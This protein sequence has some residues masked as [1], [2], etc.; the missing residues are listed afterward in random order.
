MFCTQHRASEIFLEIKQK[1]TE[2]IW[3]GAILSVINHSV[4][5]TPSKNIYLNLVLKGYSG[6]SGGRLGPEYPPSVSHC[7]YW[8][9]CNSHRS[10][11]DH[12]EDLSRCIGRG[13]RLRKARWLLQLA[14]SWPLQ[15]I[16]LFYTLVHWD[17]NFRYLLSLYEYTI[18]NYYFSTV[19]KVHKVNIMMSIIDYWFCTYYKQVTNA[20]WR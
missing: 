1:S 19:F 13:T 5:I 2:Q 4:C 20:T 8:K 6:P 10:G 17:L 18:D 3:K 11:E 16:K 12:G 7:R 15:K 14:A 9:Y